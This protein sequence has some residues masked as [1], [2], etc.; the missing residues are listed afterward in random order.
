MSLTLIFLSRAH[1]LLFALL[2]M[3]WGGLMVLAMVKGRGLN[4]VA[5]LLA[6]VACLGGAVGWGWLAARQVVVVMGAG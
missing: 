4:L 1:L 5:S 3:V 6:F 2:A